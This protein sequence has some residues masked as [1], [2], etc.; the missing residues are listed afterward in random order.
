M[1]EGRHLDSDYLDRRADRLRERTFL[2]GMRLS[3]RTALLVLF[4][5]AAAAGIAV[6]LWH[7][8]K[9]A[10]ALIESWLRAGRAATVLAR[11]ENELAE[12]R[13]HQQTFQR[14]KDTAALDAHTDVMVRL[15]ES[16]DTLDTTVRD[17]SVR[18]DVATLREAVDQYTTLFDEAERAERE[19]GLSDDEGLRGQMNQATDGLRAA[20]NAADIS[21]MDDRVT[22][23]GQRVRLVEV[24]LDDQ[25]RGAL[26]LDYD[27]I[28]SRVAQAVEDGTERAAIQR[29]IDAHR[30]AA[31][32]YINARTVLGADPQ[33]F[34]QVF[35][36]MDPSLASIRAFA[37][38]TAE[39]APQ[40]LEIRRE[41]LRT[42]VG[43]A[44][45][46]ILAVYI[47]IAV[48]LMRSVTDPLRRV[49]AAAA[50][51]AH[52]DKV[53]A[54]PAQGNA[55]SLGELARS[56]DNW[57]DDLVETDHL[58]LELEDAKARLEAAKQAEDAAA[59]RA[60]AADKRA[61]EADERAAAAAA[62]AV[63]G[64]VLTEAPAVTEAPVTAE[65]PT[66]TAAPTPDETEVPVDVVA[67]DGDAFDVAATPDF[68]DEP[69]Y[70]ETLPEAIAAGV[71]VPT[72]R[73]AVDGPGMRSPE[74]GPIFTV[75]QQLSQF[76]EYISAAARDVERTEYLIRA[77]GQTSHLVDDLTDAIAG[78]R[79]QTHALV[80]AASD[81]STEQA[82]ALAP[83][84]QAVREV[85]ERAEQI[86][87]AVRATVDDVVG[88][89]HE[90]AETASTQ[91]LEATRKLLAQ[92]EHLQAMLDDVMA[93]LQPGTKPP[94]DPEA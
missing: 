28:A 76:T 19:L 86:V 40:A 80:F 9:H 54:V 34:R 51:L 18:T 69:V 5:F 85:T 63:D 46:A 37:Q 24:P 15:G 30:T 74:Q 39:Q 3:A 47:F 22:Q 17:A 23:L 52:G 94:V 58:R 50:R 79:D 7:A 49:S 21:D 92:S 11:V 42:E 72:L 62:L 12:A 60:E 77:L 57:M 66:V 43:G 10:N 93:K 38:A 27:A 41:Q 71:H 33:R 67:Y 8:D 36:Y 1:A 68:T 16:L 26:E 25:D 2:G 6:A 48:M 44:I 70:D 59:K 87:E 55:D 56:L 29:L 45:A 4:G 35:E 82:E 73:Y 65:T 84:F 89:S 14:T 78:F 90:I 53:V 81:V 13:R 83:R 32:A 75:S 31:F 61:A 88:V 64:P 91:A 20:L